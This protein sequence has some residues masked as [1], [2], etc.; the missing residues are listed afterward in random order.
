MQKNINTGEGMRLRTVAKL[1]MVLSVVLF[2]TA[3]GF[4]GFARL[5]LADKSREIN[6][7]SLVPAD[8]IGVLESDNISY[9]LNEFPQLSYSKKLGDFQFP[10]LLSYVLGG[11]NEYTTYSAH[12]LNG[13][14][15]RMMVSFHSTDTSRDQVVY[16]RMGA[17]DEEIL[18]HMLLEKASGNFLPKKEK[19]KGKTIFIYPMNSDDFL[20]VYSEAGFYVVS[21]QKS[22]IEKVID[23]RE[24]ERKALTNNPVFAKAI[25]K[26]K[27]HNFLTLYARTSSMPFLQDSNDCWSEFDFHM[28]S[29]VVYLTGDT[30]LPDSCSCVDQMIKKLGSIQ[31]VREDSLI[32]SAD[33]ESMVRCMEEAYERE[34]RTLFNECVANLSHDAAFMFVADMARVS[35]EPE[36]FKPY[37]PSFLLENAPLLHSFILSMQ[38]SVVNDSFSHIMV[39]TYKD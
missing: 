3:V 30:F 8:C 14:M 23:A 27:T 18:T 2:C 10:G 32:I 1:G 17:D 33:K 35:K 19:Y 15:S 9:Y 29:D 37:F 22:L 34:N 4:Y 7:F 11:L 21:Y 6:L 24:D 39:L 38:L 20:A 31:E 25:Q 5:T 28:N 16:F 13:K 26:K 36:R 12:G